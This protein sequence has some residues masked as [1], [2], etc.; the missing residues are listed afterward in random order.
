MQYRPFLPGREV[1]VLG[2]GAM[3]LP[4]TFVDDQE[5][6]DRDSAIAMI[7]RALDLGVTYVDTAYGYCKGESERVVGEALVERRDGVLLAT[8]LPV[9]R[10]QEAGDARRLLEEQLTRLRTDRID[11]YHLH[12]IG[13]KAWDEKVVP[14]GI[15]DELERARSEGLFTHL[16]FSFHDQPEVMK[17]LVDTG[18]FASVLCQYNLLDRRNHEAIAYAR[19]RGLGV[20]AMGPVGGGRLGS[21]LEYIREAMG[22]KASTPELALRFVLAHPD[23]SCALS[24]MSA[25]HHVEENCATAADCGVLTEAQQARLDEVIES[26]QKLADLYCTGCGY[27]LPCPAGV[28]IPVVF[29]AMIDHQVY[30][31]TERAL[32]RYRAIGD[33]WLPGERADACVHCGEC[34]PKCPQDIPIRAQLLAVDAELGRM[35]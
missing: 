6:V 24:G 21:P 14:L 18:H 7:H 19:S 35:L 23:I 12:G 5:V 33:K 29:S 3:R 26:R 22:E 11:C 10:C 13:R 16:A 2:F 31:F 28:N 8:K 32:Q 25:M 9:H 20:V 17:E 30:G 4:T 1:S 15:I 34:E 27:C